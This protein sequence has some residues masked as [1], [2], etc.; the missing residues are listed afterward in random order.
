VRV[1]RHIA[2]SVDVLFA[3]ENGDEDAVGVSF[4]LSWSGRESVRPR[5]GALSMSSCRAGSGREK[6]EFEPLASSMRDG[7][8]F[9]CVINCDST[10]SVLL[11]AIFDIGEFSRLY[12]RYWK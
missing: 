10:A 11:S 2:Q 3:S 5:S 4:G 7:T 8:M 9:S 6:N 12:F 1:S